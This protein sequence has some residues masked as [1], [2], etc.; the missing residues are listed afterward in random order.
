MKGT[1]SFF[2]APHTNIYIVHRR[3][4]SMTKESNMGISPSFDEKKRKFAQLKGDSE[5][6]L[7]VILEEIRAKFAF[8]ALKNT[9]KLENM[10]LEMIKINEKGDSLALT[11]VINQ[12]RFH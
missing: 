3:G 5:A 7:G 1:I 4:N 6:I 2:Y 10:L 8:S 11:H 9:K 12:A